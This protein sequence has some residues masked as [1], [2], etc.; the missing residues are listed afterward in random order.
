ML[1]GYGKVLKGSQRQDKRNAAQRGLDRVH[2]LFS[3][4]Y[5]RHPGTMSVSV[6]YRVAF[7][8]VPGPAPHVNQQAYQSHAVVPAA[9]PAQGGL[10]LR[11]VDDVPLHHE[12]RGAE[13][14]VPI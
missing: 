1:S 8:G 2:G 11:G 4:A 5:V 12:R 3:S 10:H 14:V 6:S 7:I 9:D 13:K